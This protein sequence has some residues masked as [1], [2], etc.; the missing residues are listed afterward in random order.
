MEV[1][2]RPIDST[3]TYFMEIGKILSGASIDENDEENKSYKLEKIRLAL[4]FS[5][6]GLKS[7]EH[8]TD[9]TKTCR[10]IIKYIYE[11][12]KERSMMLVSSMDNT[13]LQAIQLRISSYCQWITDF[14]FVRICQNGSFSS[15]RNNRSLCN[16]ILP[17]YTLILILSKLC[18]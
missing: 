4:N 17:K 9:I 10:Q 6:A 12:P 7:C 18:S 2:S 11:D 3:A 13:K 8:D 16:A 15:I 1:C 5:E 14:H